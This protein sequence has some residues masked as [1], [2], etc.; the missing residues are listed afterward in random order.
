MQTQETEPKIVADLDR[1][2][3]LSSLN[4]EIS[5][6][7]YFDRTQNLISLSSESAL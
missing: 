6:I 1:T 5:R 4:S 7:Q 3:E 2:I